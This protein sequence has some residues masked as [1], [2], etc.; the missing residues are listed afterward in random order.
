MPASSITT[1]AAIATCFVREEN[2]NTF[3]VVNR[4]GAVALSSLGWCKLYAGSIEEVIPQARA[5]GRGKQ[6]RRG[7]PPAANRSRAASQSA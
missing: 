4:N 5:P 3:A 2:C 6:E 7:G 1:G